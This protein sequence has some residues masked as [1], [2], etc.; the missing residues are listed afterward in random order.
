[1]RKRT[2][3]TGGSTSRPELQPCHVLATVQWCVLSWDDGTRTETQFRVQPL[4]PIGDP[5][6]PSSNKN[7]RF[8]GVLRADERAR[9]VDLLHGKQTLYQLSYIREGAEYSGGYAPSF[10]R[11]SGT[12]S[13]GSGYRPSMDFV[14]TSSPSTWTSKMPPSPVTTSTVPIELSHS[15]RIRAARPAAFGRAPQ[16]TQYSMRICGRPAIG[17]S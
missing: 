4:G 17:A 5:C 8:T 3:D 9:T 14:K 1:M 16:G 7:P 11:R 15:S 13:S 6:C 10:S 2:S 12:T